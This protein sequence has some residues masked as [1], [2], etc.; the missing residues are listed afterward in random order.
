[1]VVSNLWKAQ[2]KWARPTGVLVIEVLDAKTLGRIY[3]AVLQAFFLYGP[4]T[5]VMKPRI[6][7]Y[8]GGFQHRADHRLTEWQAQREVFGRW[9]YPLMTEAMDEV[10]LQEV[11]TYVSCR[12]NTVSQFI[13]TSPIM[14]LCLEG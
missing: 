13:D 2:Q 5:W 1:M 7:R 11:E 8:F 10:G 9:L 4:E 12:Q 3:V 6:G 14:D